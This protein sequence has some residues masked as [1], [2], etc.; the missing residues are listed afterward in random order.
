MNPRRPS[1]H[2]YQLRQRRTFSQGVPW[3][4]IALASFLAGLLLGHGVG[5]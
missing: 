5:G 3:L 4:L 2:L 1:P